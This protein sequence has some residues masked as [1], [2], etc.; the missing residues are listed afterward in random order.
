[1]Y[2]EHSEPGNLIAWEWS[3]SLNWQSKLWRDWWL[4]LCNW[5]FFINQQSKEQ[6]RKRQFKAIMQWPCDT[7]AYHKDD[8]VFDT[9]H[10]PLLLVH[11]LDAPT[12]ECS[13]KRNASHL[14]FWYI[15]LLGVASR[16]RSSCIT[17]LMF[18]ISL[19]TCWLMGSSNPS[20]F[21]MICCIMYYVWFNEENN[22]LNSLGPI[23]IYTIG[24]PPQGNE[25]LP[26]SCTIG[27]SFRIW[28]W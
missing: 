26:V 8:V 11:Q 24:P 19:I 6:L 17:V 21:V 25:Q 23:A 22:F 9:P 18:C 13:C 20:L 12:S 4:M 2:C 7:M 1:M 16:M 28:C 3:D 10:H 5:E 14:F 27:F 15:S